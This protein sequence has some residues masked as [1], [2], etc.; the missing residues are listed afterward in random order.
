MGNA[1]PGMLQG[2]RVIEIADERAEYAGLLL[3]GLGA[4]VIKIEPPE[5][6][7]TRRIGPFLAD[8]PGLERSLFFWNYNRNQKSVVLELRDK[9]GQ[10]QMLRLLGGADILLDASCGALNEALGLDHAALNARF[11]ALV[12]ARMTPFGDD[13]PWKDFKGSDLI[14]LALGGPMMNC[15]YD[16]DPNLEYDTPPIAPQIWHAYHIAGAQMAT[17]IIAALIHRERSGEG[18]DVSLAIHEAVSKS[19]EQ[20]LMYWVCRRVPLWRLTCRHASEG[21]NHSPSICHTKDGRWVITHGM[22]ARDLK[23]LV[24]LLSKCNAQADLQPPAPEGDLRAR[25][26]PGTAGSDEAR[27]HM[28]DVVQRFVRAWTYKDMP[29]REAQDAGLL[30]APMRKPHENALDEHWWVRKTFAYVN[31][32][33]LGRSFRYPTSKWLATKT[34]WQVGRRAPLL[35]EDTEAVLGDAPRRP[36]VPAAPRRV[37]DPRRSA[38]HDKPFPLQGIRILDFAWFLASAGGTR[39]LAAMGAESFKVEWK[40]NPDTRLAA[41]A[42]VGGRAAR[43]AATGPLPGVRDPDMGGQLNNKNAGKRGIS[44][45]IRHPKGLQIAKDL[46]RICDVVAEG[47]SPGVLQRLGLGYDVMKS[48]RPDV[49]Y[50]QQSGM[51]AHGTYGRMRTVGPVAA[52]F[53]GQAEMSGLPEPSMPVSWGYSY[54]DWMGAYGY[55]LALL[56]AIYHRERTGE[57]QWIDASQCESGIF[58]TGATILDWSANEREFRR[59]GNRSPYKKAAP[60]GAYRCQGKDR[61]IAIACF[62]DDE[63]RALARVAGHGEWLDDRR[64][65]TLEQRLLHQDSLDAAVGA[66]TLTQERWD[67]M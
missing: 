40:D 17:G 43:D 33:D 35:G 66:W 23:N 62:S 58:L 45:N 63:W 49:I 44:L 36:S 28:L 25:Q 9:A 12:A 16:P 67:C 48:I 65:A 38:M 31:H 22:G 8:E 54:L 47:F 11:P 27:S 37:E 3:A 53:V 61:W 20:D 56:G 55:A 39:F 6:N 42:P 7:A 5:G 15:G 24:P 64:F 59:Y 30:W 21:A 57:G 13:G 32:P 4:E 19:P 51:G 18:Q 41:M 60:H 14:H 10:E 26:V 50:I 2:L 46:V 29:W 1:G 52:A 34:S